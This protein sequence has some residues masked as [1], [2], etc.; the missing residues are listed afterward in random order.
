MHALSEIA[1]AA[2]YA[3]LP[4][5]LWERAD[6]VAV[7]APRLLALNAAL[8][9]SLGLD[10]ASL[11][12]EAGVA[13]LAGNRVPKGATPLAMAYA[14]HQFGHWVP[15]LGDGR[16]ILLG[17]L[18]DRD[19]ALVDV[20]LKGAG[21]TPFS[22]GGDGRN[23]FGPALRE[24][25]VSEAMHALGVP[26]TRALA[27]VATGESVLRESGPLPGAVL[28]R[29]SRSHVRVGTFQYPAARGDA[30]AVDA[31]V[32]HVIGRHYPE[33]GDAERPALALLEAV[34]ERQAALVAHWMAL[35]FVHGVM[36][37]DNT[38][39]TGDTIDYGPCAFVDRFSAAAAFSAID[40]QRRYAWANQPSIAHWNLGVLAQSLLG[41]IDADR[42]RAVELA[43]GALDRFPERYRAAWAGRL[44]A[45]L[46]F[47]H[48]AGER[49]LA[50]GEAL[51]ALMEEVGAD[52][53]A[54]FRALARSPGSAAEAFAGDTAEGFAR[55]LDERAALLGERGVDEGAAREAMLGASPARIPRN[56]RVE[57]AIRA[58][59]EDD[60][61][62]PFERLVAGTARPYAEDDAFADLERPPGSGEA[63]TRT[64]CGT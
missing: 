59:L 58:A 55:W 64:F 33:A 11:A 35:G 56:H 30:A 46:G 29:A 25:A 5:A 41:A 1:F 17:E 24:Y 48:G 34:I 63:V 43:Q 21:R 7:R 39:I 38:S 26:T 20:H 49:E 16:A 53:T 36:N 44:G 12:D 8:A 50:L 18:A 37:T 19:G 13:T 42:A 4:P 14:G 32:A 61:L 54:T 62:D 47:A 60:D 6:P 22:R 10:P 40:V 51:L 52:F 28:V 3:R 27:V 31:L 45:K 15:S 2:D 23:H 9:E 57:G